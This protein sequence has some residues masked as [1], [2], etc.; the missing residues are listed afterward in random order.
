MMPH[1]NLHLHA[2]FEVSISNSK[3]VIDKCLKIAQIDNKFV[4]MATQNLAI[5]KILIL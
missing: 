3:K 2:K 5:F 4:S 1:A